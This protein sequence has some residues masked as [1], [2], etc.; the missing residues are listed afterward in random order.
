MTFIK[1]IHHVNVQ[2]RD[3]EATRKWYQDVLGAELL[4]R[5]PSL[6]KR[7]M[8]MRIGSSEMHF[9]DSAEPTMAPSTHFAVEVADW[10]TMLAHLEKLG[11]THS[12]T[13]PGAFATNIGGTD[14]K[15][16]RREDNGEHYSYI[17]DPD[18]NM[19]ELVY[20]PNG[21][22]DSQGKKIDPAYSPQGL[23]WAQTPDYVKS[24]YTGS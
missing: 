24:S 18:G 9:S 21:L 14:P 2:I 11:V 8:Q 20:H 6:N 4:D 22:E 19:I 10:D 3:R 13:V 1:L 15:Q 7:Q 17:H 5:G 12:R 23:R 16:G